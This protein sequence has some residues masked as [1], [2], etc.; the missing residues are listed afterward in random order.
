MSSNHAEAG[1]TPIDHSVCALYKPGHQVHFIQ[2][3]L[4][5]QEN[6][7]NYRTGKLLSVEDDGW[8]AVEVGGELLRFWNHQPERAR[9]CF[10]QSGG[11]I[12]L[13]G[14]GLLH[15]PNKRGGNYCFCVSPGG[16]TP[17]ARPS[18]AGSSPAG[19]VEQVKSHGGFMVSGA[20]TLRN[21]R[22]DDGVE[23]EGNSDEPSGSR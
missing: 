4:G 11:R 15:A 1:P 23:D 14:Y 10:E 22:K 12:G 13:P 20:D 17:C 5:W 6:R 16:P 3:K 21:V 7:A 8:I 19:L 2:A 18:T 9:W